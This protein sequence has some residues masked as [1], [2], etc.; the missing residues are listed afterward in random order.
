MTVGRHQGSSLL[1]VGSLRGMRMCITSIHGRRNY[2]DTKPEMSSLLVFDKFYR[3]E[4]QSVMLVF[5]TPLVN[6]CPSTFSL[7]L[8]PSPLPKIIVQYIQYR[9]FVAVGGC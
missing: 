3:L 6:C 2:K 1:A 8:T 5:S 4:I 7:T 9:Q